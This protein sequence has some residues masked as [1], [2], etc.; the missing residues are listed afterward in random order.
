L[1]RRF[2]GVAEERFWTGRAYQLLIDERG[3]TFGDSHEIQQS[4]NQIGELSYQVVGTRGWS[5][6]LPQ[7]QEI[8]LTRQELEEASMLNS[9][10]AIQGIRYLGPAGSISIIDMYNCKGKIVKTL[11]SNS[12]GEISYRL[13]LKER[14]TFSKLRIESIGNDN[15]PQRLYLDIWDPEEKDRNLFDKFVLHPLVLGKAGLAT[16]F[17]DFEP[18]LWPKHP[19][20]HSSFHSK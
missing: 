17:E 4:R 5:P 9:K 19:L 2:T 18:I 6:V 15:L 11:K 8:V 16:T 10:R 14:R 7:K 1:D 12:I 20:K 3:K 13:S